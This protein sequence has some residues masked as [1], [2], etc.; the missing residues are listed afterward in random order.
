[1]KSGGA[2]LMRWWPQAEFPTQAIL[3]NNCSLFR[4]AI[5]FPLQHSAT[6]RWQE[7]FT[8][9]YLHLMDSCRTHLVKINYLLIVQ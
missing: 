6:V 7:Y 5:W 4:K 3:I 8:F 1:M 2:A 9:C